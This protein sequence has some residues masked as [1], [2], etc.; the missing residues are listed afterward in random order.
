MSNSLDPDQARHFVRPDRLQTVCKGYQQTI[1]HVVGKEL[2]MQFYLSV[3]APPPSYAECAFGRQDIRDENHD[4]HTS[5]D[6]NWAPA[7]PYYDWSRHSNMLFGG[8]APG[9]ARPNPPEYD[10]I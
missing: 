8:E 1:L 10:Q 9:I 2:S 4:E 5:G 7:Y 6:T 3:T